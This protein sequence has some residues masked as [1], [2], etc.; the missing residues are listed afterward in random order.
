MGGGA[1]GTEQRQGQE[2]E[3]QNKGKKRNTEE[4]LKMKKARK[5]PS[6]LGQ[7]A[8]SAEHHDICRHG[9]IVG[10]FS[11]S[12]LTPGEYFKVRNLRSEVSIRN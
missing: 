5:A 12:S 7:Q 8:V 1:A 2:K 3:A 6:L 4:K 9:S 10:K 11:G